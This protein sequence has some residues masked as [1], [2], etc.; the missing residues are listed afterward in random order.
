M[1]SLGAE[2]SFIEVGFSLIHLDASMASEETESG[3]FFNTQILCSRRKFPLIWRNGINFI[4]MKT[5]MASKDL[6]SPWY[7]NLT[8]LAKVLW[9]QNQNKRA[10]CTLL[11]YLTLLL[12]SGVLQTNCAELAAAWGAQR[13]LNRFNPVA[14]LP[15]RLMLL[16]SEWMLLT[17]CQFTVAFSKFF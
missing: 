10:K 7:W 6:I 4:N 9:L 11:K 17:C 3:F 5:W 15:G 1:S 12:K 16:E 13:Y 14:A 8:K 2:R